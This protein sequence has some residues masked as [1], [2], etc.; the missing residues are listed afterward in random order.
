M[1]LQSQLDRHVGEE[2][3]GQGAVPQALLARAAQALTPSMLPKVLCGLLERSA[4]ET[5]YITKDLT[6]GYV[7]AAARAL[8]GKT[9]ADTVGRPVAEA[10]DQAG[11]GNLVHA[12]TAVLRTG[13]YCHYEIKRRSVRLDAEHW[14]RVTVTPDCAADGEVLGAFVFSEDIHEEKIARSTVRAQQQLIDQHLDNG[15]LAFVQTDLS[16]RI[17]RWSHSAMRL[18]GWTAEE[19]VGKTYLELGSVHPDD[20]EAVA[21]S[22]A[23]AAQEGHS[24]R[25]Y[26]RNRNVTKD[27]RVI[28][29]DWYNGY[30]SDSATGVGVLMCFAIDMTE[31]VEAKKALTHA[32]KRDALTGIPNRQ[33][34]YEWLSERLAQPEVKG[35]VFFVDL[36]GFKEVNDRYGHDT[37]DRV[38]IKVTERLQAEVAEDEMFARYGGDEFVLFKATDSIDSSSSLFAN[39]IVASLR[40][41]FEVNNLSIEL[42]C[43]I[44]VTSVPEHGLVAETLVRDADLAMYEAKSNGKDQFALYS[45]WLGESRRQRI[46]LHAGLRDAIR[47]GQLEV[48]YQ[49]RVSLAT[50]HILGAEALLRWRKTDGAFVSP[51]HFIPVAEETGLIHEIG[52]MVFE[53]ACTLARFINAAGGA[54]FVVSVNLSTVQLRYERFAEQTE[55]VLQRLECRPE[56]VE[57]EVTESQELTDPRCLDR[58]SDLAK[59]IGVPCALDDFGTGYSNLAELTR[60]PVYALKIDRAFVSELTPSNASIVAAILAL[61]RSLNLTT[62]AE[63]VE[64]DAQAEQLHAMGCDAYQGYLHSRPMPKSEL[65]SRFFPKATP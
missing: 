53:Q 28:W 49:P 5:A 48:W 10:Y 21:A 2:E 6:W 50:G 30:V 34:F 52:A 37:G 46:D 43:S 45:Q 38:L 57:F 59:R 23:Q 25:T 7:N 64:N 56:W 9:I 15:V 62:I 22:S 54:P 31:R 17:Q 41:P 33:A 1:R 58:L 24:A 40:R 26:S 36:D 19:A 29:C 61:A 27:G 47:R 35:Y 55:V 16:Y 14:F 51:V 11:P 20:V 60:L 32:A 8:L 13:A 65:I 4:N 63:G 3:L 42:S 44:G 12:V 39:R 18:L